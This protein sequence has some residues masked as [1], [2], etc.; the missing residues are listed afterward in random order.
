MSSQEAYQILGLP[1][2]IL[3]NEDGIQA[4]WDNYEFHGISTG[5]QD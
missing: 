2:M 3:Y 5:I 1:S 4:V